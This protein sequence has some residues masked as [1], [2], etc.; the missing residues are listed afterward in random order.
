MAE[1]PNFF[2]V[3]FLE[4]RMYS[5][6]RLKDIISFSEDTMKQMA[7]NECYVEVIVQEASEEY[8]AY[9][10]Q[11][12]IDRVT[13]EGLCQHVCRRA[14]KNHSIDTILQSFRRIA[15][16]TRQRLQNVS[17]RKCRP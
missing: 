17:V 16:G 7:R 5:V 2:V 8:R 1:F 3:Y 14:E 9:V 4:S 13:M 6:V 10:V 11:G 12:G 15:S